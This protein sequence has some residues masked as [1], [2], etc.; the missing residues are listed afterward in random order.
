MAHERTAQLSASPPL[1]ESRL[2]DFF[3]RIHP[4]IPA[5]VFIPV[6]I[7]GI[8]LAIDRGLGAGIA[9]LLVLAGIAIWT[10]TEYWLHRLLFHWEPEVPR[11]RSPPLHHP[12]RPP[13][14]PQRR[15]APGDA[16]GGQHPA[17]GALPRSLRPRLRHP[18]GL[19]ALRRVHRR[20]P[21]LRLHPLP[22][23]PPHPE[24]EAGQADCASSTCATTSRTT[25]TASASPRRSG[26]WS[27]APCR[28]GGSPPARPTRASQPDSGARAPSRT[29]ITF[30]AT[31]RAIA[32]RAVT[33][34]EPMWGSE[35]A[36]RRLEQRG[37]DL[38][39]V[40]VD[41]EPGG[42]ER[43]ALERGG[44]RLGIDQRAA[45]GVDEDAAGPDPARARPPP[46]R[47]RVS[48]VDGRVKADHVASDSSSSPSSP[49]AGA[50]PLSAS[51]FGLRAV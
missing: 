27:S 24:D 12:R 10:L 35:H 5:I 33:V 40:L 41:V 9:A 26:T 15:D 11:R 39:L 21:D 45:G 25:A 23:A 13:R 2:L 47:W 43:P 48:G 49:L 32:S 28:G 50:E 34:A 30:S 17:G 42:A 51:G 18:R 37:R 8:W 20:L 38:R 44:E 31:R 36:S 22:P 6:V 4:A 16:A 46:I 1:F 29:A 19:P 14:P 3:S 7:G